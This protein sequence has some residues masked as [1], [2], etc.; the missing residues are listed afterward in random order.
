MREREQEVRNINK[1]MHQVNEIYK[2][3][4]L[5]IILKKLKKQTLPLYSQKK[6]ASKL[7][8]I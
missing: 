2:V 8:Y 7:M 4:I 6:H 5:L 1:G 3:N